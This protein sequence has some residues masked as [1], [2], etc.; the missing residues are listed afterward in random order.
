MRRASKKGKMGVM[1]MP[2]LNIIAAKG[3]VLQVEKWRGSWEYRVKDETS[4]E[5][6][7]L[8]NDRT[9]DGW[10][11]VGIGQFSE[12]KGTRMLHLEGICL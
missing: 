4:A 1:H 5:T 3:N 2:D 9:Q 12:I 6:L 11:V 10:P 7:Q 8:L